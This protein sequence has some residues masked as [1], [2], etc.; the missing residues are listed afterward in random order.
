MTAIARPAAGEY[1]P[2]SGGYVALTPALDD[3]IRQLTAQRDRVHAV[4]ARLSRDR[5]GY[6]YAPDK[7]TVRD[8]LGHVCDTERIL[9]Y[10]LLRVAR[11]DATP[12]PG[13]D[14]N[15]Y[16]PAAAFDRRS[17][18]D[19]IDE[20]MAVRGAT[21]A[22]VRGMPDEAWTRRGVANAV[23]V[24]ARGVLYVLVGHVEHHLKML[25]ARYGVQ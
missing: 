22:L 4:Y 7:W 23:A 24:T 11:G 21:I 10:R 3:P 9:S 8:V 25:D 14:E 19:V 6:R 2:A 15:T 18:A 12:L 13:F 20:W 17:M 5:A 1:D 16:V